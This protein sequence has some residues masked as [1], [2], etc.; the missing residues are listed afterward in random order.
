MLERRPHRKGKSRLAI[1]KFRSANLETPRGRK[2]APTFQKKLVVIDYM[3]GPTKAPCRF[4]IKEVHVWI[5]GM[6]PEIEVTAT[7]DDVRK[8]IGEVIKNSDPTLGACD[9]EF[10]EASGKC[11]C[12]PAQKASFEWT[13]KAVKQLAG[14]GAVYVRLTVERSDEDDSC[15]DSE[16]MF[17]DSS[18]DSLPR[19]KVTKKEC[20]GIINGILIGYLS[21]VDN[22]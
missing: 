6:L 3:G 22:T 10:M 4:A 12:V 20:A 1:E 7:E 13:G 11:L 19:V 5:R 15:N 21:C 9:F 14:S 17:S 18:S 16:V 8:V 2:P